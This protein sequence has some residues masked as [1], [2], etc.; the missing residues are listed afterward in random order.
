MTG[1]REDDHA[2]HVGR[3][4]GVYFTGSMAVIAVIA[5]T[6]GAGWRGWATAALLVGTVGWY[7]LAGRRLL[8]PEE[9]Y[10]SPRTIPFLVGLVALMVPALA[11]TTTA[12]FAMF[13]VSPLAFMTGGAWLGTATAAALLF[14]PI[15][16]RVASGSLPWAAAV[17]ELLIFLV[18]LF[19]SLWF[20]RWFARVI[21]Q[22]HERADLIAALRA[23]REESTRLSEE[24]GALAERERLARELHDTL[25]QGL[26]S[27]ITLSQAVESELDTDPALAR[28]HV[29]LMR[30][31]ATE[32]LAEA[33]AMVAARQPVQLE[34]ETLEAALSRITGRFGS[35][36][37]VAARLRVV[38]APGV[39]PGAHQVGLLRATQEALANIRK[40]AGAGRADV[41]L[42]FAPESVE[43]TVTDDGRGFVP[44]GSGGHGLN[45]MRARA[46]ALGGLVEV[47]SAPGAGTTV[48]LVLPLDPEPPSDAA[49]TTRVASCERRAAP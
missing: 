15:L 8:S 17:P 21:A 4:W 23:S 3:A 39:L 14:G 11:L 43:L 27:I 2:W 36:I 9:Y 30:E 48:R 29:A 45:G 47:E 37:G 19:F 18:I 31:T 25:A 44:G 40:H 24:A 41:T 22:S 6:T 16:F 34:N 5:V 35:E 46:D 33:R 26:T 10:G 7:F 42:S 28:R 49:P 20:A 1:E 32:N 38:G 13:A 12:T